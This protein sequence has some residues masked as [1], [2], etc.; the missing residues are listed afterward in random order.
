MKYMKCTI[1]TVA[2][3][4]GLILLFSLLT[5]CQEPSIVSQEVIP[6]GWEAVST[7]GNVT[8]LQMKEGSG[9]YRWMD[10]EEFYSSRTEYY[11]VDWE[12]PGNPDLNSMKADDDGNFYVIVYYGFM[13]VRYISG[14]F[15]FELLDRFYSGEDKTYQ[16]RMWWQ[17]NNS[18]RV[19]MDLDQQSVGENTM[20]LHDSWWGGDPRGGRVGF[21]QAVLVKLPLSEFSDFS[22]KTNFALCSSEDGGENYHTEAF[23]T[24][25][26]TAVNDTIVFSY[27]KLV[28]ETVSQY[29]L[30]LLGEYFEPMVMLCYLLALALMIASTILGKSRRIHLIPCIIGGVYTLCEITRMAILRSL[31]QG[32]FESNYNYNEAGQLVWLIFMLFRFIEWGVLLWLI[33]KLIDRIR[34]RI[35]E[36]K[37]AKEEITEKTDDLA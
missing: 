20:V 12:I 11:F 4:L 28:E 36:K 33:R 17:E 7:E 32:V 26:H 1:S 8:Y 19:L 9:A 5:A 30:S 15:E 18:P 29:P 23:D 10:Y 3:L 14:A 35:R 25:S 2:T 6:D 21:T 13:S 27:S 31:N 22:N 34:Q 37:K 24:M 16:L